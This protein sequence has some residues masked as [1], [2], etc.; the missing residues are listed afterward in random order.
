MK[1]ENNGH[2]LF[3]AAALVVLALQPLASPVSAQTTGAT[4][5]AVPPVSAR[6]TSAASTAADATG[7]ADASG[8]ADA[9]GTTAVDAGTTVP[10]LNADAASATTPVITVPTDDAGLADTRHRAS[11]NVAPLSLTDAIYLTLQ[12]N[13][14]REAAQAAVVAA[15]ARIRGARAQGRPQVDLNGDV[16]LDRSFGQQQTS[17]GGVP[18]GGG[19]VPGG[20]GGSTGGGSSSSTPTFL[21]FNRSASLGVSANVP[22]YTGG[23]VRAGTRVA[24]AQARAQAAQTLQIEQDLVLSTVDAYLSILRSGQLLEVA[25]NDVEISRERLRIAQVRFEAGASPRLDVFTAQATLAEAQTN[26]IEASNALAQSKAALNTLLS[27]APETPLRVEPITR[28]TLQVPLPAGIGVPANSGAVPSTQEDTAAGA[29][30]ATPSA[31]AATGATGANATSGAAGATGAAN[32]GGLTAASGENGN[33]AQLR[34][35]A[36]QARPLLQQGREQVNAAE[37][38]I[39]VA[40]AQRRPNLG[41]SI[42]SILR[43][44]VSSVGR[45]ALSLG[46]GVAQTLFDSGRISSQVEEARATREQ[47]RQDLQG[48]RLQIANQIEQN[49][50]SLDSSAGRERNAT[51]GVLAAQE[52]LRAAQIGYQAGARTALDVS[53]AQAQLLQAQTQAVN[54]R[55]DVA[56]SQAQLSAAVGIL[57][58]E[59][60]AA[61]QR[62]L[63]AEQTQQANLQRVAARQKK[64]R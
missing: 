52:A 43:D 44:P 33:S 34:A 24:E 18:G 5:T 14:Q 30:A 27:R 54:A 19:G 17:F 47:F 35:L 64:K 59:G 3:A 15:R 21:G 16:G 29:A 6:S 23:R 13:P 31:N 61:Y 57:T 48:Q 4:A 41:L 25:E 45:F 20:G 58:T 8:A 9:T 42:G 51:V 36:E 10:P 62:A 12:N 63:E 2:A 32:A 60:Q 56:L 40:R 50:L 39:D 49:L 7:T 53:D 1:Y 46:L 37:A 26:R 28:L 55:F 22:V 11:G 38:N